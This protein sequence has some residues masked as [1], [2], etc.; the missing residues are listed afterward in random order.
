MKKGIFLLAVIF[1]LFS[2]GG[3]GSKVKNTDISDKSTYS[4]LAFAIVQSAKDKL[5]SA[6]SVS[7]AMD[8]DRQLTLDITGFFVEYEKDISEDPVESE[9]F[10]ARLDSMMADFKSL[11]EKKMSGYAVIE[12]L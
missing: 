3:N 7:K 6:E 11:L 8:I 9:L 12:Q 5:A 4:D 10:V 2:C 1:L